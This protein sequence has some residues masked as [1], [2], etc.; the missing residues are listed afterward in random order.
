MAYADTN[1]SG[2]RRTAVL[3]VI[4]IHAGIGALLVA[5][6]ATSVIPMPKDK[7]LVTGQ[8]PVT[9]PPTEPPPPDTTTTTPETS[10]Q[11]VAP[12]TPVDLH[13]DRPV[14]DTTTVILPQTPPAPIPIPRVQPTLPPAPPPPKPTPS[15]D[16]VAAKPVNAPTTWVTQNDYRTSWIARDYTGEVSYRLSIGASGKVESCSVTRSSGVSALD[17]ATCQLIQRRAR[18]EPAKDSQGRATSG[19]YTSAVRWVLPD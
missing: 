4:G 14:I 10:R 1:Q 11:V 9:P 13:N 19:T 17:Q 16:P 15:V 8:I 3:A 18:F 12:R 6:L 2:D 7:P 5:G